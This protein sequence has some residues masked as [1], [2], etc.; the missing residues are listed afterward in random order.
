MGVRARGIPGDL[1]LSS[2]V[3]FWV[4]SSGKL[5]KARANC[6]L[7]TDLTVANMAGLGP[8]EDGGGERGRTGW[9]KK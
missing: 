8:T 1:P 3:A 2:L 5:A 7:E 9:G 4:H 6:L